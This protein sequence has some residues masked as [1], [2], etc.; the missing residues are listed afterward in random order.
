M[1]G[2]Q[3]LKYSV[4]GQSQGYM[5]TILVVISLLGFLISGYLGLLNRLPF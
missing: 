1:F 3:S 2:G 5:L 4:S